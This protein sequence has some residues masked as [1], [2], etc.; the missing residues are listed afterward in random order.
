MEGAQRIGLLQ[1]V[2]PRSAPKAF[3]DTGGDGEGVVFIAFL[4]RRGHIVRVDVAM[5]VEK[6]GAE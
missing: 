2:T 6:R 1:P 4:P 3:W 5:R